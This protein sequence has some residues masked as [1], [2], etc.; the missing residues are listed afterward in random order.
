[1]ETIL[2]P[3]LSVI[4]WR[5]VSISRQTCGTNPLKLCDNK[6]TLNG[7]RV[8]IEPSRC[9]LHGWELV[10]SRWLQQVVSRVPHSQFHLV[11]FSVAAN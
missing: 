9:E 7:E 11:D 10:D 2:P 6:D 5:R 1:M 4:G 3:T 8:V